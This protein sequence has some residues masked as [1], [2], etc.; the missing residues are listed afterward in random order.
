MLWEIPSQTSPMQVIF[1]SPLF[2]NLLFQRFFLSSSV[3]RQCCLQLRTLSFATPRLQIL[4]LSV[5]ANGDKEVFGLPASVEG[6]K[7]Q[8]SPRCSF[9]EASPPRAGADVHPSLG[10]RSCAW[11]PRARSARKAGWTGHALPGTSS[12]LLQGTGMLLCVEMA[13]L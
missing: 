9:W 10:L 13:L 8:T 11:E 3:S 7:S 12:C 1:S 5:L 6:A 4:C 2:L